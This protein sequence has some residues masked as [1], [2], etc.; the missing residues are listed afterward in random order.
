L[1]SLGDNHITHVGSTLIFAQDGIVDVANSLPNE[2]RFSNTEPGSPWL[3]D[4]KYRYGNL[5]QGKARTIMVRSQNG[6][7]LAVFAGDHVE[8]F[9]TDVPKSTAFRIDGRYLLIYRADYTVY[10]TALLDL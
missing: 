5:W 9:S 8:S 2:V 6:T 1:I 4:I 3:N 7:P 10:D